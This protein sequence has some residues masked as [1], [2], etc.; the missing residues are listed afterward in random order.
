MNTLNKYQRQVIEH[1]KLKSNLQKYVT[2]LHKLKCSK[3]S[4]NDKIDEKKERFLN[5]KI[6]NINKLLFQ[7]KE[8]NPKY[9]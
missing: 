7:D 8:G 2:L 5:K 4:K 3:K 1:N 9:N 6:A